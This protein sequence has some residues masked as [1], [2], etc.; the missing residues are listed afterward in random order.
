MSDFIKKLD[1]L[2]E[3]PKSDFMSYR[4]EHDQSS[5]STDFI[6]AYEKEAMKYI[7]EMKPLYEIGRE[8][9]IM[10]KLRE[11]DKKIVCDLKKKNK[12]WD[13]INLPD[14]IAK[15]R[16]FTRGFDDYRN[17]RVVKQ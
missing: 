11:I 10:K 4:K 7:D 13:S 14:Y 3:E 2:F 17:N 12:E 9:D 15:L 1:K 8:S 5:T 6:D 16:V